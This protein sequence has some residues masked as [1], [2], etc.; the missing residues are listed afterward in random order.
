M[1]KSS[2]FIFPLII[3]FLLF[4][5]TVVLLVTVLAYRQY[6]DLPLSQFS[7]EI[8]I[9]ICNTL[10][11]DKSDSF[12]SQPSIQDADTFREMLHQQYPR[13]ETSY[14]DIVSKLTLVRSK[15]SYHCENPV[16]TDFGWALNNCPSSN[17][18]S[19]GETTYTCSFS[20]RSSGQSV[21]LDISFYQENGI[22]SGYGASSPSID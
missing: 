20:L 13:D 22:V 16:S 18:C 12:C 9:E 3:G 1:E 21:R 14:D 4:L 5:V 17:Q 6:D 15:P 19:N 10:E 2:S 8:V 11:I 7:S